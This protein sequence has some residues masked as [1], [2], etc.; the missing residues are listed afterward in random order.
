MKDKQTNNPTGSRHSASNENH[1]FILCLVSSLLLLLELARNLNGKKEN[2]EIL[3]GNESCTKLQGQ[4]TA[5]HKAD[6]KTKEVYM[7]CK[8]NMRQM[9]ICWLIC[10]RAPF[11][12]LHS[13]QTWL[14]KDPGNFSPSL[15]N[16]L[17]HFLSLLFLFSFFKFH[18]A[19]HRRISLHHQQN[20]HTPRAS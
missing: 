16:S 1:V 3:F 10:H 20:P 19:T 2:L 14:T 5:N 18:T 6:G 8:K 12:H 7:H 13:D 4:I 15:A 11:V 17:P 9:V